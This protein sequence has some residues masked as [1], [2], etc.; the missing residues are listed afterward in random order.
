M[1][2]EVMFF[3]QG[4][5][6]YLKAVMMKRFYVLAESQYKPWGKLMLNEPE[7]VKIIGIKYEL[8]PPRLCCLRLAIMRPNGKLTSDRFTIKYHDIPDVIDFFV[9][10]QTYDIAMERQ[11][12]VGDKF[13]SMI[14]DGWWWGTIESRTKSNSKFL[15]YR[16]KW[17]NGESEAMSPWDMEPIDHNREP[18]VEGGSVPV[19]PEEIA[20][21]LYHP[22][23]DEWPGGDRESACQ[24][25]LSGLEEIMGLAVAEP[26]NAPVDINVY[27][28]YSYIVE[29]PID[30]STVKARFENRFYRRVTAAQFDI[31]YLATNTEKFNEPHSSI[32]KQARIV[33]DLCLRLCKDYNVFDVPLLYRQ[34]LDT[35][36]SSASEPDEPKPSTSKELPRKERAAANR[37][38]RAMNR[39]HQQQPDWRRDCLQLL[40]VLFNCQ[41]SEPFREPVDRLEHPDYDK[42]ID[43]P[44]DLGTAREEL[45]GGNYTNPLEFCKDIRMIFSNSRN[46]NTNKRSKIYVMTVRLSAMA[47]EHMK[48]IISNWKSSLRRQIREDQG[49][50]K[51]RR[52]PPPEDGKR[53]RIQITTPVLRLKMVIQT[54][55]PKN[56]L[57]TR[58]GRRNLP[59]KFMTRMYM[60]NPLVCVAEMF[61]Q[62]NVR[63]PVLLALTPKKNP[64]HWILLMAH[65]VHLTKKKVHHPKL[66]ARSHE[67]TK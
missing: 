5:E 19:L 53:S 50:G 14:D 54:T 65:L 44:M 31:R 24:R 49:G 62:Q 9:L 61:L 29:F 37:S 20:A 66:L 56:Q 57:G 46:Y 4:Y 39:A 18:E 47:E 36:H 67:R 51:T 33:T 52:K 13:R 16:I 45:L 38:L 1:G 64:M 22:R 7:F 30:L 42:V 25:I 63:L 23:G 3:A 8:R 34:L 6:L 17:D 48:R 58:E 32:V 41:D 43:T 60:E 10:K 59:L 28:T 21:I 55:T 15:G 40:D 12:K 11:W 26:F 2:D 27:P 35:Y